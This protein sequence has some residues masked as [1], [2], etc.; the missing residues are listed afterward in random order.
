[1]RRRCGPLASPLSGALIP[2]KPP[3][4]FFHFHNGGWRSC[5][6]LYER[7][8]TVPVVLRW[9]FCL[10]FTRAG[11]QILRSGYHAAERKFFQDLSH[12]AVPVKISPRLVT[13]I[14]SMDQSYQSMDQSG[15]I[16]LTRLIQ[17]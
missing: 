6:D 17:E 13:W 16:V 15:T 2:R 8:A 10:S 7:D 1:M 5:F 3:P 9:Q 12:H 14:G 11:G 4:F